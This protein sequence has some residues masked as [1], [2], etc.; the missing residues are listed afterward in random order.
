MAVPLVFVS[1]IH[2]LILS[3]S[4][5]ISLYLPSSFLF[6]FPSFVNRKK[7]FCSV[8]QA[9]T[10]HP[11]IQKKNLPRFLYVLYTL[12]FNFMYCCIA[13]YATVIPLLK[14]WINHSTTFVII[15]LFNF[16]DFRFSQ[17]SFFYIYRYIHF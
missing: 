8:H 16:C 1:N 5:F 10:Q 6:S 3:S 4:F 15:F 7:I 17:L 12:P 11:K 13:I 14:L 2:I 9:H